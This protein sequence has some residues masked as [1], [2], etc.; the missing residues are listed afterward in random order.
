MKLN[1]LTEEEKKMEEEEMDYP[2]HLG[3]TEA[4]EGEEGRIKSSI[5]IGSL[6]Q[7]GLGDTIRVSLTEDSIHEIPVAYELVREANNRFILNNGVILSPETSRGAKNPGSILKSHE[8]ILNYE[9][10]ATKEIPSSHPHGGHHPV[11]VWASYGAHE[12]EKFKAEYQIYLSDR[13][14]IDRPLE[15]LE[16]KAA[17]ATEILPWLEYL[18]GVHQK[19]GFRVKPLVA[20][21]TNNPSLVQ[22]LKGI[23]KVVAVVCNAS[24]VNQWKDFLSHNKT[25]LE[26]CLDLSHAKEERL[27]QLVE[28]IKNLYPQNETPSFFSLKSPEAIYDYRCLAKLLGEKKWDYLI[29]LRYMIKKEKFPVLSTATLMGSLLTDGLGDGFVLSKG[30]LAER[31]S[32]A[33]NI[34]Q[35]VRLRMSQTEYISCPSCGRTLF[36]L[37]TTTDRIRQK[38]NHLKGIKIAVMGCIVNGPGEMADADFGYVGTGPK[39]VSLYVGKECVER[40]IPEEQA[41]DR[42]IGLIKSHHQWVEPMI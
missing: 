5:G 17:K 8:L 16:I 24:E 12:C 36:N 31:L 23:D 14:G 15:G 4:G 13:K 20:L 18:E 3:V 27:N 37:Q 21:Q 35:G 26:W 28:A 34:L 1:P 7:D 41:V 38:T 6:L 39:K 9:R 32:L 2:F 22:E 30:S 33:Y 11:R 42:L 19:G 10:R 25:C 29:Q 40:N